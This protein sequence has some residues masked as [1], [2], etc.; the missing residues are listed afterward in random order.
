MKP[1]EVMISDK[2]Y[3]A[4]P[5]EEQT[6]IKHRVIETYA[7]VYMSKLGAR[8]NTLFVDCHGGCGA[9][10]DQNNNLY[11]GSSIRVHQV[12][13]SVFAHRQTKNGII[14]CESDTKTYENLIKVVGD[15][16]IRDI[17]IFPNNYNEVLRKP[18]VIEYY[19]KYPTLFF[20]DPFGYY[21]TPMEN[22]RNLMRPFGNE[23][24]INFMFD[25]LNRGI[26]IS[27]IQ[28]DQ[29]TS[30]FGSN[31]WC[32]ARELSGLER[33]RFLVNLYKK[34]LKK[35]TGAKYVFAYRLC[36][37][38]RNQTYYYLIHATK[39]IQG[40]GCMKECFALIN[41]GRVEFLGKR[42]SEISL[43]DMDF[44]K[45]NEI[46]YLLKN[47]YAGRKISFQEMWEDIV[48]DTAVLEKDLRATLKAMEKQREIEVVRFTSK[49]PKGLSGNDQI[50]FTEE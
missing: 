35:K 30:F 3:F 15:L 8:S 10:V 22:M 48:E 5:Y 17:M 7:K 2:N 33:E 36:Y 16:K 23:I 9:Y 32:K 6:Q 19:Q 42:N 50:I 28:E 14:I 38:N 41:N 25:F 46:N 4:W 18:N 31:E 47:K 43:F 24:I 13:E 26:S 45:Q 37:P 12:S 39:N 34:N 21:D 1:S 29:L 40:I 44:F 11:F 49:T 20:I 27:A